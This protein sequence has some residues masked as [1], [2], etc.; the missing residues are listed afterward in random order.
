MKHIS[1]VKQAPLESNI[2]WD[3]PLNARIL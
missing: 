1:F 2:S 3:I